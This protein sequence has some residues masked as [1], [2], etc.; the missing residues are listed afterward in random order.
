MLLSQRLRLACAT[1][2]VAAW[3]APNHYQPWLAAHS[4]FMAALSVALLGASTLQRS[5]PR[6]LLSVP[7]ATGFFLLLA[8]IPI[9]QLAT[10]EI[11]FVGDA[12]VAVLYLTCMAFA[13]QWSDQACRA[14]MGS[15][16]TCFAAALLC[17]AVLSSLIAVTQQW[18]TDTGPLSLFIAQVPPGGAPFANLAQ[19]NHLA[20]LLALGLAGALFLFETKRIS[21]GLALSLALLLILVLVMTQSRTAIL[22][23]AVAIGWHLAEAKRLALRTPRA[24]LVAMTFLWGLLFLT[25]PKM[26]EGM[27]FA[28]AR[29]T[30]SRLTAGPRTVIWPQLWDAVLR[31]PWSGYG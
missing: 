29:S 10:G 12:W 2:L 23:L 8:V 27:H 20:T 24:L 1:V 16:P 6:N 7:S 22:L 31:A 21:A 17:G 19:P 28:I 11:Y 18:Q 15:W 4:E 3:L 30:A 14:D 13:V 9:C 26:V 5:I 25:W